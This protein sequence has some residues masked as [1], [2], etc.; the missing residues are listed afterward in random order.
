MDFVSWCIN[1]VVYKLFNFLIVFVIV[2]F[3]KMIL[4][5]VIF[6]WYKLFNKIIIIKLNIIKFS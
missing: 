4:L 6:F 3:K 1:R 2:K 5:R